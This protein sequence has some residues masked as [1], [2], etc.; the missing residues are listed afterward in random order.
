[1]E[2]AIQVPVRLDANTF[3]RFAWFDTFIRKKGWRAPTLFMGIFLTFAGIAFA[4]GKPQ[5]GLI[6]GV[7]LTVA[8]GLPAVYL[9]SFLGQVKEQITRNHLNTSRKVYTVTLEESGITVVN[10][11]LR[12][13][14]LH[15]EWGQ[16]CGACRRRGCVYLYVTESRAFLL[17]DGQASADSE[18]LWRMIQQK[19][20]ARAAND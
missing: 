16:I 11:Q 4:S 20:G 13:E 12:E 14:P 9:A 19:T 6:G 17:P 5:S 7:L 1:M 8:L 3:R 15:M 10:H 2:T 18:T